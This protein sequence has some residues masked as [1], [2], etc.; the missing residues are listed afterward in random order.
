MMAA[1]LG[2][3]GRPGSLAVINGRFQPFHLGHL[4][5]AKEAAKG[6][7]TL[8]VGLTRVPGLDAV[9]PSSDFAPHRMLDEHN[10]MTFAERALVAEAALDADPD[11]TS[12]VIVCPF[13]IERPGLLGMFVPTG[14][15]IVTTEHEPWNQE[16][17]RILREL[18]YQ[19]DVVC[20]TSPKVIHGREIRRQMRGGS[21]SWREDVAPAAA[22]VLDRIELPR[23]MLEEGWA[24]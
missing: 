1:Q 17:I 6:S 2:G 21:E 22:E 18:G 23:R 7:E 8:V 3:A 9:A 15:R 5:Y 11:F 16:K 13:P 12:K 10:P 24:S 4:H 19:V 20:Q 14:W